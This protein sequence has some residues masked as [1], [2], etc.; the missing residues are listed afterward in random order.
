MTNKPKQESPAKPAADSLPQRG[1]THSGLTRLGIYFAFALG[2]A[3]LAVK[4][5]W[6]GTV[7]NAAAIVGGSGGGGSDML[8]EALPA[9]DSLRAALRGLVIAVVTAVAFSVPISITYSVTRRKEGYERGIVQMLI[10]LP[11]V[12]AGVVLVVKGSVALAFMLTGIVAVVRFRAT[13]RD[14][15][16]AVF[17]FSA[18]AV[19]LAA[20]MHSIV[21]AAGMSFIFCLLT[22]LLWRFDVGDLRIDQARIEGAVKLSDALVPMGTNDSMVRGE[23]VSS[24]NG[25][26]PELAEEAARLERII[27]TDAES[28]K[29]KSRFT[30]LL[31]VHTN[32]AKPTRDEVEN[33]LDKSAKRWRFV[34]EVP[35]SNG[36]RT[37]EFLA[38]LRPS[39][40]ESKF[41]SSIQHQKEV[42]GVELKAV[43]ALRE[44]VTA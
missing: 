34:S 4:L 6:D 20:G 27:Q 8:S 41:L 19:G 32:K 7:E 30:H 22:I 18:L 11:V 10:I 15:K 13:F 26:T 3:A 44:A 28:H 36:T 29:Q 38:R 40:N 16:D 2:L 24:L 9:T 33:M 1:W 21:I 31:L 12:V 23:D 5:G 39:A 17:G 42:V 37:L 25:H 43:G 14:V 35:Y